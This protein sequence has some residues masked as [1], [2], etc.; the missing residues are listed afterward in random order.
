MDN[1]N[2]M[3]LCCVHEEGDD[4]KPCNYANKKLKKLGKKYHDYYMKKIYNCASEDLSYLM[5]KKDFVEEF[6]GL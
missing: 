2:E 3:Q 1:I 5:G 6:F 4:P